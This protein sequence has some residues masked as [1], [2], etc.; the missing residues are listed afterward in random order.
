MKAK[1]AEAVVHLMVARDPQQCADVILKFLIGVN[2]ARAGA[3]FSIDGDMRLFVGHGITQEA[4]DWTDECWRRDQKTLQQGRLSRSD[5]RFLV[6]VLRGE[7]LAALVYLAAGQLDLGSVTEVSSL[8]AEAVIRS[9]REP[10]A[11]S[12]VENY[13]EQTPVKEIERRKL[14]ILLDRHEW[15]VARVARELRVTRTTVYKRLASFGIPRKRVAKEGR[16]PCSV[17][18]SS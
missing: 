15:N 7:R 16:I 3:V 6:P 4:L 13:L 14:V 10:A 12:P 1:S 2:G 8:I 9:S 18:M 5:D 11:A 17:T